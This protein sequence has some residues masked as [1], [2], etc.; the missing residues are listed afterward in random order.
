MASG[1]GGAQVPRLADYAV[2]YVLVSAPVDR[3]LSRALDSLPGLVRVSAPGGDA[4]WRLEVPVTRVRLVGKDGAV[5]PVPSGPVGA[6]VDVPPSEGG[7]RL[8][9]SEAAAAGWKATLDGQPLLPGLHDGWAQAFE[10]RSTGGEL[11]VRYEDAARTRWLL[12]Q[13]AA[14]LTVVVLALPGGAR[15][16]EDEEEQPPPSARRHARSE[17]EPVAGAPDRPRAP[18]RAHAAADGGAHDLA[19]ARS[20]S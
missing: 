3:A 6:R 12:V 16:P 11:V 7:R 20:R 4:L 17:P 9:L 5:T 14:L 19:G 8:V 13:A 2:R 18:A 1:R 10:V 15:R